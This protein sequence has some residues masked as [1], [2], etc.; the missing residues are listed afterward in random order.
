MF[1]TA[2]AIGPHSYR[3]SAAPA[4]NLNQ[5]WQGENAIMTVDAA[6]QE[7][8]P[9]GE[10]PS[11]EP[12]TPQAAQAAESSEAQSGESTQSAESTGAQNSDSQT[13]EGDDKPKQQ[14]KPRKQ[15]T[16]KKTRSVEL[17]LT[18]TGTV[19]G[20]WQADVVHGTKRVVRGLDIPAAAVA[21]AAKE[22]H[23]D[24]SG[25][26]EQVLEAAREQHRSRVEELQAELEKAQKALAELQE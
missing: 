22:L 18:V 3:S 12:E 6:T 11:T 20:D 14:R 1:Y 15:S 5:H 9:N 7:H 4:R 26:I 17:T 2:C 8:T 25:A 23:E 19:D 13:T 21:R 16:A 10:A 24:I